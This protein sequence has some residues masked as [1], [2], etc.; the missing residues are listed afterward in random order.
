MNMK[1]IFSTLNHAKISL[2]LIALAIITML[3][4]LKAHLL[5]YNH[6]ATPKTIHHLQL[7]S[8]TTTSTF[9][10]LYTYTHYIKCARE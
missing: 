7:L 9:I 1:K 2:T 3:T 8:I 4:D 5:L 10:L 6:T